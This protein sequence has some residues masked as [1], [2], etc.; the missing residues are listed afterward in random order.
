M[1][2]QRPPSRPSAA[3]TWPKAENRLQLSSAELAALGIDTTAP[4][5]TNSD[6]RIFGF[7]DVGA[8]FLFAPEDSYWRAGKF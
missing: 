1:T 5:L 6:L 8:G 2:S 7:L 3:A 4:T